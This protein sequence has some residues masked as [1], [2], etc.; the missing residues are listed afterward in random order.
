MDLTKN[1]EQKDE[2]MNSNWKL[3]LT[4]M[5]VGALLMLGGSNAWAD[6]ATFDLV[7]G[8][9]SPGLGCC[10]GPYAQVTIDLTSSTTATVTFDSLTNG[11]FT[12]LMGANQGV[13]INVNGTATTT[14][15]T[16]S[17]SISGFSAP[18]LSDGGA[19]SF[20]GFGS[21]S[22]TVS[23][24][25]GFTHT[26]T[27]VSFLLT[28][29]SG[30]WS[31][32]ANVLAAN[33]DGNSLAIHGFACATPCTVTEGAAFT[34]FATGNTP[35]A[36]PEPRTLPLMCAFAGLLAVCFRFRRGVGAAN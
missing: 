12:Y 6:I 22:N 19:G 5:A 30:T 26:A 27:E 29:T 32:A 10:T 11:G 14:D 36:T 16:G 35:V 13:G 18:V 8:N 23:F 1:F 17:N 15:I 25:D 20:D 3:H 7:T 9:A 34:G 21:F 33:S 4:A 2:F 28:D 31:S 24:F